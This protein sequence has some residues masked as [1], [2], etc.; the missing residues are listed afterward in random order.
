V[1]AGLMF[2]SSWAYL[3]ALE[4]LVVYGC[5]VIGLRAAF[6]VVLV[7]FGWDVL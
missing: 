3:G 4:A 7:I 1:F 5:F 2:L 6:W